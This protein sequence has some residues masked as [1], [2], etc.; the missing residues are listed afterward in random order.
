MHIVMIN[1]V[2]GTGGTGRICTD[3]ADLLHASGHRCTVFYGRET[4]PDRYAD[5]SVRVG[6]PLGVKTHALLARMTDSAGWHSKTATRHMIRQIEALRPDVIHLHNLHGYYLDCETLFEYLKGAGIPVVW[7]LHDCWPFTGH[8]AHYDYRGCTRWQTG[9]EDCPAKRDYPA[10]L[11]L[12][13]SKAHYVKK[14]ALFTGVEPLTLAA[15]SDWMKDQAARSFLKDYPITRIYNGVDRRFFHPDPGDER[16][17]LGI[18]QRKMFLGLAAPWTKRKGFDFFIRLAGQ[19][20]EDEVIV[21]AGLGKDQI[22]R[23]PKGIIGLERIL[24]PARLARLY[25]AADVVLNPSFEESFG[26]VTAEALACG[27][28]VIVQNTTA[29]PEMVDETC[30]RVLQRGD[31]EGLRG[32]VDDLLRQAIPQEACLKRAERF[33]R[34]RNGQRYLDLYRQC[35]AR[36]KR[37]AD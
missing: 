20:R 23:M 15:V 34:E 26:M 19:L 35:A 2:S 18:G 17:V 29:S 37:S 3:L 12:D 27:T 5:L 33:D 30:G 14:K 25:S 21:M 6:G 7:T 4:V 28:P 32:T 1:V 11:F 31:L 13:R 24:D 22:A 36:K 8:C 16:Q 10:S 9:C